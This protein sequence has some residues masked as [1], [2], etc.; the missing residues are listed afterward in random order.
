[1]NSAASQEAPEEH[2]PEAQAYGPG[3]PAGAPRPV[4]LR[5][6]G[7]DRRL[8]LR[9]ER[10]LL[11]VLREELAMAGTKRACGIGDCGSCTVLMDGRP[12]YACLLL[13][14]DCDDCE[15]TT[16]EALAVDG[17]PSGSMPPKR[18][19]ARPGARPLGSRRHE[20]R[21]IMEPFE[22]SRAADLTQVF[23]LASPNRGEHAQVLAG[24]T[25]LLPLMKAGISV[26]KRLV[27]IKRIADLD[28]G[29][30]ATEDG[31]AVIPALVS[32]EEVQ[33]SALLARRYRLL[34]EAAASS[35]TPQLRHVATVGG[36]LLQRPRCWYFRSPYFACWLKGGETCPA[37][38]GHNRLH[39]L[40]GHGSRCC[41][42][43][44]SDLAT[45]LAAL[46][47]DV[48]LLS[49]AGDA[50]SVPIRGFFVL[51]TNDR[52]RENVLGDDEL[53]A[54]VRLPALE[55]RAYT[56]YVKAMNRETGSFAA[57]S[58]AAV[59]T[60]DADRIAEAR[61][62]LGGVA[63]IPWRAAAAESYLAGRRLTR[64]QI[65]HAAGAAVADAAPLTRNA[66][67]VPLA[68]ALVRRALGLIVHRSMVERRAGGRDEQEDDRR[69][70]SEPKGPAKPR[71]PGEGKASKEELDHELDEE[72]ADTFP[73]S[74]P[75]SLTEKPR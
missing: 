47:A 32:L 12:V 2:V 13:A 43:H 65:E 74:D 62:A 38:E 27:D 10:T 9:P 3:A 22:Y 59:V 57:A 61:I 70:Q 48:L 60:F 67:K 11:H 68:R 41:A 28:G 15:I 58:A 49:S 72:L 1:M 19:T 16:I 69:E 63:P 66:Y 25:D 5:I 40:F 35:A 55:R 34:G 23:A 31:G 54:A 4:T 30:E 64:M 8:W 37:R 18:D 39:A 6:N 21:N 24:G 73:A 36:N 51:P 14:L 20:E 46:D 17:R 53:L 42:V 50:R 75:P 52:R 26:P 29:I 33:Y 7:R 56:A 44:P 45:C 71:A